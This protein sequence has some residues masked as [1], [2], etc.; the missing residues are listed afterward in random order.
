MKYG[1]LEVIGIGEDACR[2]IGAQV[3][4]II[5]QE[6]SP[7]LLALTEN[8]RS[9]FEQLV[10]DNMGLIRMSDLELVYCLQRIGVDIE[11][12]KNNTD[13]DIAEEMHQ[14]CKAFAEVLQERTVITYDGLYRLL[15]GRVAKTEE[16]SDIALNYTESVTHWCEVFRHKIDQLFKS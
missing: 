5:N 11:V 2:H 10:V 13:Q 8:Y 16:Y 7:K 6:F 12:Y 4:L 1:V 9:Y 14:L 3:S 15:R